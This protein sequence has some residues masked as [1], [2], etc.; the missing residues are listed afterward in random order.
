MHPP[1]NNQPPS[2]GR[3]HID[4]PVVA[5]V[6][7]T[8][9]GKTALALAI[10]ER[11]SCEIVGADSMQVYRHMDIGTAKPTLEERSRIRHHL[12][13]VADPDEQYQ[14]ARYADEAFQACLDIVA[15]GKTPMLVGGTGLYLQALL[16]GMFDMPLVSAGVRDGLRARLS[17][18]GREALYCELQRV[19]PASAA[20]IHP[21]DTQRLLRGLEIF[22]TTGI[23]WSR[24]LEEQRKHPHFS[25]VVKIGLTCDRETLYDRINKR[26]KRMMGDGLLKEVRQLMALGYGG[27]LKPM[28]SLGYRHMVN[29]INGL[30]SFDEAVEF[31]A[32][33]TRRYAKR[34]LTWFGRDPHLHWHSVDQEGEIRQMVGKFLGR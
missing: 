7:P 31:L 14:A 17:E 1:I 13:D 33:D 4:Q 27:E 15:R 26:V 5:I 18:E 34:Q 12:I 11:F 32:R 8:A 16:H 30:W 23:P 10:A 29:Y 22:L 20:R 9:V 21:N 6:G 3:Q 28:Q 19:D 25:M 24:H 2:L